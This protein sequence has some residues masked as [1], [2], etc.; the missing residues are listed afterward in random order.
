MEKTTIK[1][2]MTGNVVS[3]KMTKTVV[4]EV[5]SVKVHPKYHKRYSVTKKYPAHV[6]EGEYQIGD[7]VEIEECPPVSKT[8]NWV[9]IG[10]VTKA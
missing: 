2:R 10:K 8:V 6:K 3:N 4:V 7:K 9:V 5:S 1:R